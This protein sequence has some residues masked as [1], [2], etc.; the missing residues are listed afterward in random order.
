MPSMH[1]IQLDR[2]DTPEQAA[3]C[4]ARTLETAARVAVEQ[5]GAFSLALSGG[6]TPLLLFRLLS[7]PEWRDHLP[8]AQTTVAWVD[9]RCVAPEHAD[10][11]YGAARAALTPLARVRRVL[12][13][14]GGLPPEEGALAYERDLSIAFSLP[15]GE[16]PRFDCILLGMGGDG[17][18]A[19]LFPGSSGLLE[20]RRAVRAQYPV[21]APHARLTLT[22]PVLNAARLCLV[23]VTGREKRAPLRRALSLL[24]EPDL[25]IQYLKPD[26]GTL[27]WIV[28][29]AAAG[30][31]GAK[32]TL[33]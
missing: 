1:R 28:D 17:H 23:L 5:R 11:N 25:P 8:W 10:S 7:S 31:D 29:A 24:E 4:A 26:R 27:H 12:P 33:K 16:M 13:M 6:S 9:E 3:E 18:T 2:A 14:D 20:M 30:S 32:A 21:T 15:D 19:S 22:L